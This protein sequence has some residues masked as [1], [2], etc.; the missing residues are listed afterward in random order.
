MS[1]FEKM[2]EI[3][4]RDTSTSIRGYVFR[5]F[6]SEKRRFIPPYCF[7]RK[8]NVSRS[9][10]MAE[11]LDRDTSVAGYFVPELVQGSLKNGLGLVQDCF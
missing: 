4:D 9:G 1:R 7:F 3:S 2:A 5:V 6:P 10:K 8:G 11:I